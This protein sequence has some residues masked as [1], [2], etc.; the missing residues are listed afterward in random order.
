MSEFEI[1]RL[2]LTCTISVIEGHRRV[3]DGTSNQIEA[4]PIVLTKELLRTAPRRITFS[5]YVG[6]ALDL[7]SWFL[8]IISVARQ[9]RNAVR[10]QPIKY[11][12][13]PI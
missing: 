3:D 1:F 6:A 12:A 4:Q 7:L 10:G 9:Y 8:Y 5:A 11:R 13:K 2:E